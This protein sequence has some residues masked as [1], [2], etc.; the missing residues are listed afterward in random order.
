MSATLSVPSAVP[1][2]RQ[3]SLPV[4]VK[5]WKKSA[6]PKSTRSVTSGPARV[7]LIVATGSVPRVVPSVFQRTVPPG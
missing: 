4:A 5:A 3:S 2:L 7:G 6:P 1:S